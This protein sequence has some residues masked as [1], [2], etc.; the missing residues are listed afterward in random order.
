M[1]VSRLLR[2]GLGKLLVAVRG[3]EAVDPAR[4][5]ADPPAERAA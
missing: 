2:S 1:Q 3:G 5:V 4:I